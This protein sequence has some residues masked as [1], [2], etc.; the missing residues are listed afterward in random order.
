VAVGA[1][2]AVDPAAT[3]PL[4]GSSGAVAAVLAG[5]LRLYPGA[6]VLALVPVPLWATIVEVPALA[7]AA[8]WVV[9]QAIFVALELGAPAY[10]APAAGCLFGLVAIRLFARRPKVLDAAA[11]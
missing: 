10:A 1:Q 9:L 8:L 5:Y 7:M 3:T 4:V 11:G 2:V 6:G